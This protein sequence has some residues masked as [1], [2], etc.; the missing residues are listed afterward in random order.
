MTRQMTT[1][2]D[3]ARLHVPAGDAA[4]GPWSL[5]LDP[6]RAGWEFSGLRVV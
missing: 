5:D 3:N 4:D 6:R 2:T 1:P